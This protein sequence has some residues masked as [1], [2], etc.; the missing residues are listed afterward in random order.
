M[1]INLKKRLLLAGSAALIAASAIA[2]LPSGTA[3]ANTAQRVAMRTQTPVATEGT[4]NLEKARQL[5]AEGSHD[6]AI[7]YLKAFVDANPNA[8][9]SPAALLEIGKCQKEVFEKNR[10]LMVD[11]VIKSYE[12][13][14][15][16]FP[17]SEDTA[18]AYYQMGQL[19][20]KELKES[21][22][23][24][25]YYEKCIYNF[26]M[27]Q[28][29]ASAHY[30]MGQIYEN[31]L[32]DYDSA[33]ISYTKL[34]NDFYKFQI[35]VDARLRIEEIYEKKLKDARRAEDAYKEI[36]AAYP[37]NKKMPDVLM[38]FARF[39]RDRGD[40][41]NAVK[42]CQQLIERFPKD[43]TVR[44]AYEEIADI[45]EEKRDYQ[46]LAQT[47]IKL[48]E[49]DPNAEKADQTLFKIGQV[50]ETNLRAYKKKRIDDV[51]Y[52]KLDKA[53]L[54]ESIKYYTK[55]V[56]TYPQSKYAPTALMRIAEVLQNDLYKGIEAKYMYKAIVDKYPESKE[57][58][59][60][61]A[62]YDRVR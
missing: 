62:T 56:D 52:F 10:L 41:E 29:A 5:M 31:D 21:K 42:T 22:E 55:L 23:A 20:E 45:Y 59:S 6:K 14:A 58:A 57:Y 43:P 27:S 11:N 40:T 54:E 13:M 33:I 36:I 32:K 1:M 49:Y 26:P 19:Y 2:T 25:K 53:P 28:Q 24:I 12:D 38:N 48:Y 9:E 35:A 17:D 15:N 37:E 16:R 60:A 46:N 47:Y 30:R 8:E 44:D 18:L 50:Y 61:L 4:S 34:S 39:Y 51:T 3:S 7:A